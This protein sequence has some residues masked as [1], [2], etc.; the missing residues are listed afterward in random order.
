MQRNGV[1]W[2]MNI[3]ITGATGFVG[4]RL[5]Q[6]KNQLFDKRDRLILLTS[7]EIDGF[8]C[9]LHKDYKYIKADF[10]RKDICQ[11]DCVIYL[12]HFLQELH[13]E[14]SPT[15]GNI[16][17]INNIMH[18]IKNIP[19]TPKTFVYCS[20]MAVYGEHRNDFV[21]EN[22]ELHIENVYAASKYIIELYLRE[23]CIKNKIN[24]HILRLSHI[25]GPGDKRRYTI[26]IWLQAS[27]NYQSIMLYA[28]PGQKRNCLYVDDCCRFIAKAAY[29][30]EEADVINVV[31]EHN[32]TMGE[33]AQ[34]CK[35]I[36][37]NQRDILLEGDCSGNMG[38]GF[39]NCDRRKRY[40]GDE[41]YNL[42]EG[43]TIE[44]DYFMERR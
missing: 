14:M 3:L 17:S 1:G 24:L 21:D 13:Y 43:L 8:D 22:S 18:L 42:E 35:I 19:S 28:N 41:R 39:L 33:I 34:L 23:I 30:D 38:L 11:I 29:L 37:G 20:S 32:A 26:P 9:I 2:E 5:L 6:M 40:L 25:Y 27:S 12:G 36:S 4:S 15:E 16:S 44:Y 31:S 7:K 10:L